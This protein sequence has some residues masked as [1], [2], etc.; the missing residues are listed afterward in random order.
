[1]GKIEKLLLNP[2]PTSFDVFAIF[3]QKKGEKKA[4]PKLSSYYSASNV[5]LLNE[6]KTSK[7]YFGLTKTPTQSQK[8][9]H[10]FTETKTTLPFSIH[11]HPTSPRRKR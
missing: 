1:M 3:C 11:L 8:S 2:K 5:T 4:C 9:S 10:K 7:L 6:D